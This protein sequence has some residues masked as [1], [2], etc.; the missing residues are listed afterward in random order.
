MKPGEIFFTSKIVSD[1]LYKCT[2]GTKNWRAG[3]KAVKNEPHDWR[4]TVPIKTT[5]HRCARKVLTI[6][7]CDFKSTLFIDF[8]LERNTVNTV[9]YCQVLAK[10]KLVYQNKKRSFWVRSMLHLLDNTRQ[11]H[12]VALTQQKF[13]EMRWTTDWTPF[14]Y[15]ESFALWES[16]LW[17]PKKRH[18]KLFQWQPWNQGICK[19]FQLT[20]LHLKRVEN[21]LK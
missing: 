3:H 16:P 18:L 15:S 13:E 1:Q 20:S 14:L 7:I 10:V 6:S 2:S 11:S 9:Y 4:E 17:T 19:R 5:I 8:L 21:L 12:T